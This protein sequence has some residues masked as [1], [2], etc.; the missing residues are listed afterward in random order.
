[1]KDLSEEEK[2]LLA[3]EIEQ[4]LNT[5]TNLPAAIRVHMKEGFETILI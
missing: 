4:K 2:A 3:L 1:M 5:L